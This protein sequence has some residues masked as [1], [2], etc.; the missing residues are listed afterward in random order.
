MSA[1]LL[2]ANPAYVLP[3][4]DGARDGKLDQLASSLVLSTDFD[5]RSGQGPTCILPGTHTLATPQGDQKRHFTRI[6]DEWVTEESH[7]EC[8]AGTVVLIHCACYAAI[9]EG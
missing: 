2:S 1:N 9:D 5:S 8:E 6:P 3:A 4:K 7:L